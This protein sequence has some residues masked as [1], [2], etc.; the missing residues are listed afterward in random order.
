MLCLCFQAQSPLPAKPGLYLLWAVETSVQRS[1]LPP[2]TEKNGKSVKNGVFLMKKVFP[3]LKKGMF[4]SE[5]G[6][7]VEKSLPA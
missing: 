5:K 7:G 6:C 2:P 4:P 1:E 3:G